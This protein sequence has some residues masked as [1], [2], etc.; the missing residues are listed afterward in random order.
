MNRTIL[1]TLL[2]AITPDVAGVLCKSTDA[3]ER[4]VN[5]EIE[6]DDEINMVNDG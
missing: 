4:A 5:N 3:T 1:L 6:G 2:A